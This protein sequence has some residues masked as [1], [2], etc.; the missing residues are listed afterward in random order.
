ME[1]TSFTDSKTA[2]TMPPSLRSFTRKWWV[3]NRERLAEWY[4]IYFHTIA[5]TILIFVN[6]WLGY[7]SFLIFFAQWFNVDSGPIGFFNLFLENPNGPYV[8]LLEFFYV[9]LHHNLALWII[10]VLNLPLLT[11]LYSTTTQPIMKGYDTWIS[12]TSR[13]GRK[14][15][16]IL[17]GIPFILTF[18]SIFAWYVRQY[19]FDF[20]TTVQSDKD[21]LVVRSME[22]FGYVL[23][24]VPV[25]ISLFSVYLIAKEFYRN[26]DVQDMF[27]KWE[28]GLL[29]S[30]SFTLRG[31]TC[32]VIVGWEKDTNKPI[33]LS[34]NSRYLHE[35]IVGATGTGKTS[36]SILI[37]ITQDLIRIARGR[38]MGIVVL[39]PKGDLI[40]DVQKLCKQLGIPAHKI[41][42]VD[43]TDLVRSI[44]FNPFVG[45]LE[46]AAETFRGVLDA[47]AGDQDEFFKGQ[48]NE[49]ASLY[50]ML[51]KIRYGNLFSIVQMQQMYSDPRYLANMTEQVRA[52]IDKELMTADLDPD[53]K[54]DLERYDR[55]VSYFEN[56][57]LDYK[58]YREKD[59][60]VHPVVYQSG[61]KYEGYQV[62]ENKKDKFVTGAKKYLNDIVMNTM[63]SQLMVANEGEQALDIDKFLEE[64]GVLLVNTALGELEELSL[65]FGQFFIRQF[66]SSVFRRP[67]DE[68]GIKRCPIFFN[69]D[70][71]PLYINEAFVRLLTLG[72]SFKVGTLIA[73]QSLGQ[74][75]VV[76]QG[77][78]NTVMNSARN[79][80]VFGGGE[81]E[82]NERFSKHFGE[83]PQVE[84][85]MNESTT[86]VSMPNQSWG[87]RYNTQRKLAARFSPTDI[88]EQEFK[89]FIVD[90]VDGDGSV[91][92]PIMSYGKFINETKFIKKFVNIG[93]I[94]FETKNHKPIAVT[95]HMLSHMNLLR[96]LF[97]DTNAGEQGPRQMV[98]ESASETI[99]KTDVEM[100]PT[101]PAE[102]QQIVAAPLNPAPVPV[103]TTTSAGL[104]NVERNESLPLTGTEHHSV[105]NYVSK[106]NYEESPIEVELHP[107][108]DDEEH[109][110]TKVSLTPEEEA[111][112]S[113]FTDN[114]MERERESFEQDVVADVSKED[115]SESNNSD[116]TGLPAEMEKS[117]NTLFDQLDV[118]QTV[119]EEHNSLLPADETST[120]GWTLE[121]IEIDSSKQVAVLLP[122]SPGE[123]AAPSDQIEESSDEP[124]KVPPVD[125]EIF[126]LV[127]PDKRGNR[128]TQQ[129]IALTKFAQ[130]ADTEVD[131]D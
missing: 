14:G 34:E 71:F 98:Q 107:I 81:F 110:S 1:E 125:P 2:E 89:H 56:D 118:N 52:A 104:Q 20:F 94:E 39:E 100:L 88:K 36:T 42:I 43:P 4:R 67:P 62:V 102:Q 60:S 91:R 31:K 48:Q 35:L 37:R 127:A 8:S 74:L 11:W 126:D 69:I 12:W 55:I 17:S 50:T 21:Y 86:P 78:D 79:K 131:D 93:Q 5:V 115:G 68:S 124:Q 18:C 76:K 129:E 46:A 28:F 30:Q 120:D 122:T 103:S 111:E 32:D 44:K 119:T 13:R 7:S 64:G 9:P 97:N 92:S 109:S 123:V 83:E 80:T 58:T 23:M 49:T 128:Q 72:R 3:D 101:S 15:A 112:Y 63:L 84:E 114:T 75:K 16:A 77:F 65:S 22:S 106:S 40:R 99:E 53:K 51:G 6:L 38:R 47:L 59:G 57:I 19:L 113:F 116:G 29:A 73:I 95:A 85:S 130:L 27:Y 82:D 121:D 108:E 41:K 54:S 25:F 70:E 26:E 117:L 96:P 33:V 45:P 105:S 61:H 90:L 87:M 10:V 66:Q 24:C